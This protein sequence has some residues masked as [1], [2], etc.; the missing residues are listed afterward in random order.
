MQEKNEE[1]IKIK[2]K[3]SEDQGTKKCNCTVCEQDF[4]KVKYIVHKKHH[5]E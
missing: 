1:Q 2:I 4:N 3:D 5:Q